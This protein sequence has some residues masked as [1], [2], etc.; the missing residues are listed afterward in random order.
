MTRVLCTVIIV[1]LSFCLLV[2]PPC[3]HYIYANDHSKSPVVFQPPALKL[4]HL[5]FYSNFYYLVCEERG[6]RTLIYLPLTQTHNRWG[7]QERYFASWSWQE[8]ESF[9]PL[10]LPI[11]D[12]VA[13]LFL[14]LLHLLIFIA[15][16]IDI[17]VQHNENI[18]FEH[19]S[20]DTICLTSSTWYW[21]VQQPSKSQRF[22]L[23]EGCTRW[24]K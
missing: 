19:F 14:S 5:K 23:S 21:L 2:C 15:R 12:K 1:L 16:D 6:G 4:I 10:W 18:L 17:S 9:G 3:P 13:N 7:L 24:K 20:F 22:F 8:I 11:I